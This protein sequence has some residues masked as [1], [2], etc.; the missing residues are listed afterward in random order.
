ME[1]R[2][3][4]TII[5][6]S[7]RT[8]LH[9]QINVLFGVLQRSLNLTHDIPRRYVGICTYLVAEVGNELQTDIN[10]QDSFGV[11]C[12]VLRPSAHT[13]MRNST[14]IPT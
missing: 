14:M 10:I 12:R 2:T 6:W 13:T 4:T 7:D 5:F 8:Y 3:P 1:L 9:C 11:R